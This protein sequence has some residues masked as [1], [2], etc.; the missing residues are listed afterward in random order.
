MD[1]IN[2]LV[3]IVQVVIAYLSWRWSTKKYK[4]AKSQSN[5]TRLTD[6]YLKFFEASPYDKF[7]QG[8]LFVPYTANLFVVELSQQDKKL[9]VCA[10]EVHLLTF[11]DKSKEALN[12]NSAVTNARNK[13]SSF[14]IALSLYINSGKYFEDL[15]KANK[16]TADKFNTKVTLQSLTIN[17]TMRVFYTQQFEETQ[18]MKKVFS[19]LED[20]TTALNDENFDVH[21]HK[22]FVKIS[23]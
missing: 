4:L 7:S 14:Y 5:I 11:G 2:A 6:I 3:A 18:G 23:S 17:P 15:D 16:A 13:F 12:L 22:Y 1:P 21:F 8:V 20:L 10:N 9:L 19:T